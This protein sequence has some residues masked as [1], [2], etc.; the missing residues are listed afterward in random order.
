[1]S[2]FRSELER[3]GS[4]Q[5]MRVTGSVAALRG[6]TLLVDDLPLPVGS[7]VRV[8]TG[9][10]GGTLGEI[11]G[12]D[13]RQAV[14]MTLE[15]AVGVRAGDRVEGLHC[16]PT[17]PVGPRL[18][19]RVIDGLAR[20]VDDGP[21]V[22]DAT[23]MPLN[24]S[25]T[26]PLRRRRIDQPL[27]TG[28]RALDGMATAGQGQRLGLFAGPGVGK[29][30]L[31]GSIARNTEA[32][33][34]VIVL[35]GE[36]GREVRDFLENALGEE[37]RKRSVVVVSTSDESPLMRVRAVRVACAAAEFFRDRGD[38]VL[39]MMDSVTRLAQA[40]RQI[41]LAAG[42]PPATRGFTPSVFALLP[43][44][45]ERAGAL[46]GGG[47]ITGFYTVLVEGDETLDPVADAVRGVLDGHIALSPDLAR[48]GRY[49][50]V[51]VLGSIS[52]VADDVCDEQ[53][54]AARRQLIR[55]L[56]AHKEVEELIQIGAYA[57]GS[58]ATADVA[59]EML[60]RIEAFLRQRPDDAAAFD[61][62]RKQLLGLAIDAGERLNRSG[63]VAA[64][65][66]AG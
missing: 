5:T 48:Q 6:L 12:F 56:A 15:G 46:E 55:L 35:V 43:S 16:S 31:L 1:M 64:G 9:A 47:S 34:N 53:H 28:V 65:A 29:S 3:L 19:G 18:L 20:P 22:A 27:I 14:V 7:L 33:V 52:R 63:A 36:R 37:G 25:P 30:T 60:P 24:P 13:G 40:Q 4:L 61:S 11:V 38:N 62:T 39:L 57:S 59:I 50:A 44:V 10:D 21:A 45:L 26:S 42:E 17:A 51:D 58:N 8:G 32:D 2:G 54:I 23:L 49:P 41:G 66:G